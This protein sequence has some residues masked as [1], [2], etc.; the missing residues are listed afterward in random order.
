MFLKYILHEYNMIQ[1]YLQGTIFDVFQNM[2]PLD[3]ITSFF[4]LHQNSCNFVEIS[5]EVC[6]TI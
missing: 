1:I 5:R 2:Y 4:K 6:R 3:G